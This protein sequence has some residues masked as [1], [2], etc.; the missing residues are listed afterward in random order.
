[1]WFDFE[2]RIQVQPPQQI[3]DLVLQNFL[4]LSARGDAHESQKPW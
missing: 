3:C 4:P 2:A 1:M